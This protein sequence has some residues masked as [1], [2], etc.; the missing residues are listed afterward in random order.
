MRDP[1]E[2]QKHLRGVTYPATRD[3]LIEAAEHEDAPE[4]VLDELRALDEETHFD[5][6]DE[7]MEA[8]G[9]D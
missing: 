2:V 6:P 3:E 7:V 9:G 1:I 4:E 5:G 8:L